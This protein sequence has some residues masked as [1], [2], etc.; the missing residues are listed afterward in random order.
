MINNYTVLNNQSLTDIAV[1]ELGSALAVMDL[2][3]AN[4]LAVTDN[5]QPGQVLIIPSSAFENKQVVTF[6][7]T[8]GLTV[9]TLA[10]DPEETDLNEY[11][12]PGI[13]PYLF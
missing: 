9:A 2:A 5:I 6:F 3:L 1:Q 7:K 12:I 10:I 11:L 4:G 8:K 13:L